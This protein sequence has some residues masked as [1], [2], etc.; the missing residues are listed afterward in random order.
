MNFSTAFFLLL[1]LVRFYLNRKTLYALYYPL[2]IGLVS[3]LYII[4]SKAIRINDN[5]TV[6][7]SILEPSLRLSEP[8]CLFYLHHRIHCNCIVFID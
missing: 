1:T 3:L 4:K 7:V 6:R 5:A 8:Y 2:T